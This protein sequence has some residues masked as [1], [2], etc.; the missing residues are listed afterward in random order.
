MFTS[1]KP[2]VNN[3]IFD[4]LTKVVTDRLSHYKERFPSFTIIR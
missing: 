1:M 2:N 3:A 4:F